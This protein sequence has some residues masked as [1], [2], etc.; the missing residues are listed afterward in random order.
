MHAITTN[1]PDY[2]AKAVEKL[3]SVLDP[4]MGVSVVDLGLIEQI[5]VDVAAQK[6][7]CRMTLTTAFCPLGDAITNRV[8]QAL[9]ETFPGF[10]AE[11]TLDFES[12]W[13]A[14]RI[15]EAGKTILHR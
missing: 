12:H 2:C 6:I 11:V 3:Y 5:D 7:Y 13:T 1:R 14:D 15:S 9:D 10:T 8:Q 4:E